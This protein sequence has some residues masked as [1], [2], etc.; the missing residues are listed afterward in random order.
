MLKYYFNEC[1][2]ENGTVPINV[3]AKYRSTTHI[4]KHTHDFYELILVCKNTLVHTLND[5]KRQMQKYDLCIISPEDCHF[6]I[7]ENQQESPCYYTI[8]IRAEYL[9]NLTDAISEN[10]LDSILSMRYT[11]VKQQVFDQCKQHLNRAL[12]LTA[13]DMDKKQFLYQT[14]IT[15]LLTEFTLN[16]VEKQAGRSLVERAYSLMTDNE[17]MSLTI[18]DIA[19]KLGYSEEHLIRTFK[20]HGEQSPCQVFTKIKLDYARE[21]LISAD[22]SVSYICDLVGYYSQHYFN[23]I[24]KKHFGCSPSFYRKKNSIPF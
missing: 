21:L 13:E 18:K 22:Y 23:K 12:F 5:Q 6:S 9:K 24:F 11:T 19:E 10:F 1:L 17:N 7:A 15:K 4:V 2:P 3:S 20:K 16:V 14:V 8:S